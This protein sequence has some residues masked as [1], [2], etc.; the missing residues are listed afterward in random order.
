MLRRVAPI[1]TDVWEERIAYIIR[2]KR[3]GELGLTL[4]VNSIVILF[5]VI[6]LLVTADVPSSPS[7]VT[8]MMESPRSSETSV[9]RVTIRRNI[10]EDGIL[11]SHRRENLK[12]YMTR[13]INETWQV[14][15]KIHCLYKTSLFFKMTVPET[16]QPY[17]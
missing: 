12:S 13:L 16:H 15:A 8:L 3:I 10:P 17:S 14:S 9:L 2:E 7:L 6:R 1:R 11:H 5:I 4:A